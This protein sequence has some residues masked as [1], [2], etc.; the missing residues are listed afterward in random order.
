MNEPE[1][2]SPR[3]VRALEIAG[4]QARLYTIALGVDGLADDATFGTA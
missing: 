2:S 1:R 3:D 4:R